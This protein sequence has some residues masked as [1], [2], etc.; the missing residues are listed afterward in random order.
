MPDKEADPICSCCGSIDAPSTFRLEMQGSAGSSVS[1]G[2]ICAYCSQALDR[3]VTTT[4]RAVP[5][6]PLHVPIQLE[7]HQNLPGVTY[8]IWGW[9]R[10]TSSFERHQ[11]YMGDGIPARTVTIPSDFVPMSIERNT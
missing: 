6:V 10:G 1:T 11:D 2:N 3:M 5:A 9:Q 8:K 7:H 4:T